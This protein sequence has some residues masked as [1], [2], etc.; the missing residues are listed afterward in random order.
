MFVVLISVDD[1][2]IIAKDYNA[3]KGL[4]DSPDDADPPHTF[5]FGHDY[6]GQVS[7]CQQQCS[8]EPQ[9]AAYAYF[10]TFHPGMLASACVGRSNEF[11]VM[12]PESF[13]DSGVKVDGDVDIGM[14]PL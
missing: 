2:F 13:V 10:Y 11:D 4:M 6:G 12:E 5:Y 3:I 14:I 9:C 1:G 7:W 8:D